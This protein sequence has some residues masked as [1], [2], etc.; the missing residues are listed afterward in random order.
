MGRKVKDLGMK[1]IE[2]MN[3]KTRAIDREWKNR[4]PEQFGTNKPVPMIKI[5]KHVLDDN[6]A[7]NGHHGN[8]KHCGVALVTDLGY[9]SWDGLECIE[10]E[11]PDPYIGL[12]QP[13]YDFLV[14]W[15]GF[16]YS[17]KTGRWNKPFESRTYTTLQMKRLFREINSDIHTKNTL[18]S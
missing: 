16:K 8:C 7:G 11:I 1:I 6:G 3:R 13:E 18:S 2:E 9:C 4:H 15:R 14:N 12:T 10:R 17:K 5:K